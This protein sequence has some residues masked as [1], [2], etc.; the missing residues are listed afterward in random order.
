MADPDDFVGLGP[1]FRI[2]EE[3]LRGLVDGDHF[4][5]LHADD[6]VVEFIHTVP[7]Y[8]RRI[9]GRPALIDVYR[10]YSGAM[11]LHRC[12]DLVRYHDRDAGVVVLEYA[13]EGHAVA[14]G[15]PYLNRFISVITITDRRITHWRDYLDPLAVF[16][17]LGWPE[18]G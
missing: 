12:F 18:R 13:S 1:F 8:P 2:I 10:P 17:A 14:T 3:G 11:M 9:V 16:D 4:F 6:V 15:A 5:D 7:G